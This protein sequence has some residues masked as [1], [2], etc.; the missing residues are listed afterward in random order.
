MS[1]AAEIENELT[2]LATPICEEMG[3]ELVGVRRLVQRGMTTLQVFI[4]KERADGAPGSGVDV[5][6]CARVSR[7]LSAHLDE[8]DSLIRG[9]CSLEVSSP[10]LERPLMKPEHFE[11]FEGRVARV[12]TSQ[13]IHGQRNFKG[14][15]RGFVDGSI[16]LEEDGEEKSIPFEDVVK[17][18]LIPRL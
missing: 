3:L 16:I 15:I 9:K 8:D 18:N 2:K 5:E 17:A 11:R 4:D 10:G 1:S 12:K 6:D 14:T 13:P 7:R